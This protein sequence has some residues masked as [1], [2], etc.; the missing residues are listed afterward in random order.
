MNSQMTV[1]TEVNNRMDSTK[2]K[3]LWCFFSLTKLQDIFL[4]C[5]FIAHNIISTVMMFFVIIP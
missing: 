3:I 1:L 4:V 5:Q 2:S